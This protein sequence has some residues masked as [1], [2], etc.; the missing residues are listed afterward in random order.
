[1]KK[2]TIALMGLFVLTACSDEVYQDDVNMHQNETVESNTQGGIRPMTSSSGYNSPFNPYSSANN[3]VT[4]TFR[5]TTPL[6]LELTPYGQDMYVQTFLYSLGGTMPPDS[7]TPFNAFEG[8]SFFIMPGTVETN[9]DSG[10]PMAVNAPPYTSSTGTMIYDFGS[11]TPNWRMYHYGKIYYFK[12]KIYNNMG[13]PFDEGYIRHQFY[14]ELDNSVTINDPDWEE[15][16][17]VFSLKPWHDAVVMYH[18]TQDEMCITNDPNS[19]TPP[20]LSNISITD[21]TTGAN[22]TLE[23]TSNASGIYVNFN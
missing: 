6:L 9:S 11:W 5:N 13:V 15:A 10:A 12:Y 2:C 4:T 19:T 20:L 22:H 16:G 8:K 1:M 14:G 7:G 18:T 3:G 17:I 21:P 23:F